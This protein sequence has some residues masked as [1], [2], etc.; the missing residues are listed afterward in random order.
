[1]LPHSAKLGAP[2]GRSVA[3]ANAT[4]H[5]ALRQIVVW[6]RTIVQ[7]KV[8]ERVAK[9]VAGSTVGKVIVSTRPDR[10]DC[11]KGGRASTCL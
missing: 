4:T 11:E 6:G 7:L 3:L 8:A 5:G 10:A 1:M 2:H 9:R